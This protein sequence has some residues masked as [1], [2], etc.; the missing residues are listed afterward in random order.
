MSKSNIELSKKLIAAVIMCIAKQ[1]GPSVQVFI[2]DT[3]ITLFA[4]IDLTS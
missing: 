3:S 1:E 2:I 4:R